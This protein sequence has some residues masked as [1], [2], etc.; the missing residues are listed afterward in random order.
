MPAAAGGVILAPAR[1]RCYSKQL[2]ATPAS[3]DPG[4]ALN[5]TRKNP[6]RVLITRHGFGEHNLRSDVFMGRSPDAPLT[7]EGREQARRLG[8]RLAREAAIGRIIASSLLRTMETAR[9]IAGELGM[10]AIEP[11]E[12]FWELSKGDWEGTMPRELPPEVAREL[13]A[14]PFGYRYGGAESYR[15]VVARIGPAFDGWLERCAGETL[16]FVLHGDVIRALLYHTIR[17]PAEKISDFS[18][19]PCSLSEFIHQGGHFHVVR[20]NDAAHLA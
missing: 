17:F 4:L 1:P 7:E 8:R 16:L 9:L 19:E 18:V 15:D 5:A 3:N 20:L 12:A 13:A 10:E 2:R 6:T 14:D 11:D